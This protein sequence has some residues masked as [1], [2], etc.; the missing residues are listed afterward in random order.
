M[1]HD[2]IYQ[3]RWFKTE[4][5]V[6]ILMSFDLQVKSKWENKRK[7]FE[8]FD[9]VQLEANLR[10]TLDIF[11]FTH[12]PYIYEYAVLYLCL[13][14]SRLVYACL[15]ILQKKETLLYSRK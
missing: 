7:H 12:H 6:F 3:V 8:M 2:N 9:E 14:F 4:E 5:F 11:P 13:P 1:D 15:K 10:Q